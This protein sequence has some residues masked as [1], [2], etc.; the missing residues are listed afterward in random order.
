MRPHWESSKRPLFIKTVWKDGQRHILLNNENNLKNKVQH[1]SPRSQNKSL[2]TF[3][4]SKDSTNSNFKIS[5]FKLLD[6][7]KNFDRCE[8]LS[9]CKTSLPQRKLTAVKKTVNSSIIKRQQSVTLDKKCNLSIKSYNI[10]LNNAKYFYQSYVDENK[11]CPFICSNFEFNSLSQRVLVW[12]DLALQNNEWEKNPKSIANRLNSINY[13]EKKIP[14]LKSAPV[15][16]KAKN[17][18]FTDLS[19]TFHIG[20]APEI[21][22]GTKLSFSKQ[23]TSFSNS[24]SFE[25]NDTAK[26]L[27]FISSSLEN[28]TEIIAIPDEAICDKYLRMKRQIHIFMPAL[29]DKKDD[30]ESSILNS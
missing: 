3:M 7:I 17:A 25:N 1:S 18:S 26:D 29:K 13:D 5:T 16:P 9:R 21:A 2:R 20:S 12:L 24:D 19:D 27:P 14:N 10:N 11:C 23:K 28:I 22:R 8:K 30:S 4:S 6:S 15:H